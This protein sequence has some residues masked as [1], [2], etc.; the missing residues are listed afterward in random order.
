MD[1]HH[2]I[3]FT[4]NDMIT[5]DPRIAELELLN[6]TSRNEERIGEL[7]HRNQELEEHV[8]HVTNVLGHPLGCW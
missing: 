7:E 3:N 6:Q 5:H 2:R 4:Y 1:V 8:T